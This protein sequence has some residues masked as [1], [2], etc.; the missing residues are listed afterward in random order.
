MSTIGSTLAAAGIAWIF[1]LEI[2][3]QIVEMRQRLDVAPTQTIE[4]QSGSDPAGRP[5]EERPPNIVVI[6]A[7]DLGW[8]DLS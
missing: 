7:D 6:L 1:R 3:L 5:R 4:W 2:L 8:N